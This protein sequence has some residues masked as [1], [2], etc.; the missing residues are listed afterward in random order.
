MFL[1]VLLSLF[2]PAEDAPPFWACLLSGNNGKDGDTSDSLL[3]PAMS[4][5]YENGSKPN[6][7][8][9]SQVPGHTDPLYNHQ[10]Q[11]HTA[12]APSAAN[13]NGNHR[14][15]A[16]PVSNGGPNNGRYESL[17]QYEALPSEPQQL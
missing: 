3:D 13:G 4:N 2:G 1:P 11:R 14:P 5:G 16:N 8:I 6:H 7:H 15:M 9:A 17:P 10:P 12:V